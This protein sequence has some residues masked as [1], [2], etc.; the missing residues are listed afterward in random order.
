[1][2]AKTNAQKTVIIEKDEKIDLKTGEV[3]TVGADKLN[4]VIYKETRRPDG[5]LRIQQDFSNCPTMAEQHTAHLSDI[6]YL[7]DRYKP[8]E[9]AAY[10]AGRQHYRQEILGHDFSQ[11]PDLQEAKNIIYQSRQEFE[12]L[13]DR[14]KHQFKNHLEFLKFIDNPANAQKMLDLGILTQRQIDNIIIPEPNQPNQQAVPPSPNT[15]NQ[16]QSNTPKT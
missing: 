12:K 7:M 15:Q 11:E 8:D 1:M 5:S 9:L 13:D 2:K 6:N 3:T 10:L 16:S 14:I 4:K